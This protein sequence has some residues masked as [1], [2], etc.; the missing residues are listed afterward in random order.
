MAAPLLS[1]AGLVGSPVTVGA[2]AGRVTDLVVRHAREDTYPEITGLVVRVGRRVLFAGTTDV[3]GLTGTGRQAL[4]TPA[5][6]PIF[7][8]HDGDVLLAA[9][10][11][12]QQIIDTDGVH[13]IRA[14]DLYLALIGAAVRLV[15]LDTSVRTLIRRLGPRRLRIRPAPQRAID[16]SHIDGSH[17]DGLAGALQLSA[18]HATLNRMRAGELASRVHELTGSTS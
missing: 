2:T 13:V 9:D 14:A 12:D 3:Q 6:L 15:A 7:D 17:I 10:V 1:V 18:P 11:L 4:R 16:W 8:R 5:D